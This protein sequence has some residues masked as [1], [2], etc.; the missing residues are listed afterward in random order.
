M[1]AQAT[2]APR[3]A[4]LRGILT[5]VG[6]AAILAAFLVSWPAWGL[7]QE[8]EASI[9][10]LL[11][12]LRPEYDR[13]AVLVIY[14][15]WLRADTPLPATVR[16]PIPA[17][18]GEPFA[19]GADQGEGDAPWAVPHRREVD[20][21]WATISFELESL[22]A[23]VEFYAELTLQG[24]Q[25]SYTFTW[26]GGIPIGAMAYLIQHPVGSSDMRVS[27]RADSVQA[28][29]DGLVYSQAELGP[30]TAASTQAIALSYTKT[31]SGLS[32][33]V[34]QPVVPLDASG[35]PGAAGMGDWLPLLLGGVGLLL[36]SGAGVWFWRVNRKEA[37]KGRR[38]R[39]RRP[40]AERR[41]ASGEIDASSVF[42]HSCGARAGVSD[43]FCRQCGT[44]LRQ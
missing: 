18:V 1:N 14:W 33:D 38:A 41:E 12:E 23:Q 31:G 29:G 36:L 26:P 16:V 42:C 28:E 44:R 10:R 40:S 30:Q 4:G 13:P 24:A 21:E 34:L 27:P 37:V 20:G 2:R 7:A 9:E 15:I 32:I 8:S 5:K 35:T 39:R 19:I 43:R 11:V 17:E 3:A 6:R 22:S 25:R